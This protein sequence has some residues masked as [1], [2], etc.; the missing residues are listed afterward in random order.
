MLCLESSLW[1]S[2]VAKHDLLC[3]L[4]DISR[5]RTPLKWLIYD[6]SSAL[7]YASLVGAHVGK[8]NQ[9]SVI[10]LSDILWVSIAYPVK[11]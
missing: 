10:R 1:S 4:A 3:T 8:N 11:P 6:L 7:L 5:Q 2:S 9:R